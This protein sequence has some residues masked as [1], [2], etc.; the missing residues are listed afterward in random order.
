M[1]R[2]R[3]TVRH[4][5]ADAVERIRA[6]PPTSWVGIALLGGA[7]ILIGRVT[8]STPDIGARLLRD[9]TL[10]IVGPAA[11]ALYFGGD[12]GWRINRRALLDAVLLAALVAPFYIVGSTLP[13]VREYYPMWR[14]TLELGEFLPHALQLLV[15]AFAAETYYRG[16]LCVGVRELGF[17][18]V[19]ISPVVYAMMH[20]AKPPIELVLS[21]PTDVL[22]GAVDYRSGSILP[23]TVAHGAGL[24]LLDWLVLRDPVLPPD[25]VLEALGWLPIPL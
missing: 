21:A 20:T 17:R 19:L 7:V 8:W 18:C 1:T 23:S 3:E 24:V 5:L 22:F 6:L 25:R 4:R 15:L 11:L 9:V 2:L 16:L 14:T 10:F 12:I 13:T